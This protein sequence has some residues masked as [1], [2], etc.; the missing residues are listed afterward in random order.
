MKKK[1]KNNTVQYRCIFLSSLGAKLSQRSNQGTNAFW[2]KS[3]QQR[4][5]GVCPEWLFGGEACCSPGD[6][7][8]LSRHISRQELLLCGCPAVRL[9]D[10]ERAATGIW[11][12]AVP[13]FIGNLQTFLICNDIGDCSRITSMDRCVGKF[14]IYCVIWAEVS[15]LCP[16]SH[17]GRISG[18]IG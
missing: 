11:V 3:K 14:L 17:K 16:M 2:H 5:R 8:Y 10:A 18:S 9:I 1:W 4:R 15:R 12:T 7:I 6:G 13:L